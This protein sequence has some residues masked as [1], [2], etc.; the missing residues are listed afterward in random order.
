MHIGHAGVTDAA[1][2][3]VGEA[4]NTRELIKVKVLENAPQEPRETADALA[5]SLEN[6]HVAQTIGRTIVL[7]RPDPDEPGIRLPG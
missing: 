1:L 4:F 6:V 3:S 5:A 2:D 7:Y